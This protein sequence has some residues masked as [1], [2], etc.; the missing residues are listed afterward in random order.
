MMASASGHIARNVSSSAKARHSR[1]RPGTRSTDAVVE[2][3]VSPPKRQPVLLSARL[4][5]AVSQ[6]LVDA[7]SELL[8]S[9]VIFG[10]DKVLCSVFVC[11][12]C[13]NFCGYGC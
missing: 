2:L 4:H 12:M 13:I 10:P 6:G 8:D 5:S 11:V 3:T 9:G 7:S 1:Q